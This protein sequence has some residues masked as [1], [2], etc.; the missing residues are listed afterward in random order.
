M[1]RV[2]A[3]IIL[4]DTIIRYARAVIASA[5]GNKMSTLDEML[6]GDASESL[7]AVAQEHRLAFLRRDAPERFAALE[8]AARGIQRCYRGHRAR[9]RARS[10]RRF[11]RDATPG[12]RALERLLVRMGMENHA[13]A[14]RALTLELKHLEVVSALELCQVTAMQFSEAA[15]LVLAARRGE[16]STPEGD[17]RGGAG[18]DA[19]DVDGT[20]EGAPRRAASPAPSDADA[21]VKFVAG[22]E[23]P[24]GSRAAKAVER[25]G[26][27]RGW[28][29]RRRGSRR[30]A[31]RGWSRRRRGSRERRPHDVGGGAKRRPTP[32]RLRRAGVWDGEAGRG[33]DGAPRR[34]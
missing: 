7:S 8:T 1:R 13:G 10:L 12:A 21:G 24:P 20:R 27:H 2:V 34:E 4:R 23:T 30:G 22:V 5:R 17:V 31:R 26:A 9:L 3:R 11:A 14:M 25:R 16:T 28:S 19:S 33:D 18:D 29:R 6:G 15:D 32:I